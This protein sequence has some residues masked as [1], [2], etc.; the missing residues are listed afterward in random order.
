MLPDATSREAFGKVKHLF[1]PCASVM[2]VP[3]APG[4]TPAFHSV[5]TFCLFFKIDRQGS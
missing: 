1:L 4:Q 3:V 5:R 2:P